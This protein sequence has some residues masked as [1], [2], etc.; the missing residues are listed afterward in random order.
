MANRQRRKRKQPKLNIKGRKIQES[1]KGKK[2][3]LPMGEYR[4]R[5]KI[6]ELSHPQVS[7][8][9]M[10]HNMIKLRGYEVVKTSFEKMRGQSDDIMVLDNFGEDSKELK[11]LSEE[12]GFRY[13]S[14]KPS[15]YSWEFD[16]A[17]IS[18]TIVTKAKHDIVVRLSPEIL[19]PYNFSMYISSFFNTFDPRE[20][21]IGF[22]VFNKIPNGTIKA[23]PME[24]WTI[25]KPYFIK[26]RGWDE[27]STYFRAEDHYGYGIMDYVFNCKKHV[28]DHYYLI[29]RDHKKK[30]GYEA[31][32]EWN[33]K[34]RLWNWKNQLQ[35]LKNN[36]EKNNKFVENSLW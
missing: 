28:P 30:K 36:V 22:R 14:V 7:F 4:K 20:W 6:P 10:C 3:R 34:I 16:I 35:M 1:H 33:R 18:N 13:I 2:L 17:K 27:R 21:F 32:E 19:Y 9:Y 15:K 23:T 26:A 24:E 5:R 29:H 12:F 25:Y 11:K 8:G 31:R